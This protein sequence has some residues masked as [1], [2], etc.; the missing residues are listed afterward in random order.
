MGLI[1]WWLLPI[2]AIAIVAYWVIRY[3]LK[4]RKHVVN[5]TSVP[6]AHTSRLTGTPEYRSVLK[7]YK[8]VV[9]AAIGLMTL[10]M[11]AGI[12]LSA[13][14]AAV[15]STPPIQRSRD[16]MLCLDVSGSVLKAD[17][18]LLN[19][20]GTF[21][22]HFQGQR[23][24]L[25]V[26]NSSAV[27]I[28]PLNDNYPLTSQVLKSAAQA[29]KVQKD[30]PFTYFTTGTL[31]GFSNGTSLA[32]DGLA[33]CMQYLGPNTEH[34]SQSV[35]LSTD[36]E[37]FGKTIVNMTDDQTKAKKTGTHIYTIDPGVSD[38]TLADKHSELQTIA[39]Q[40]DGR[41]YQLKNLSIDTVVNDISQHEST[42]HSG[43]PQAA[44]TDLPQP[45]L[46][47]TAVAVIIVLG[48]MWRLEL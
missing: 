19:F 1:F 37:A 29:F 18:A 7:Q 15:L 9:G 44:N 31:A 5:S 24:G 20:Y 3:L 33:T 40:T 32:G 43:V 47:V 10:G 27:T 28:L 30:E 22:D 38:T 35:I 6:I 34:R 45:F 14:P 42:Y 48:L 13:R 8:I 26:F 25:T 46:Y 41:Y 16:I 17:S 36:N 39:S 11:I 21:V 12:I 23:F 4:R 2:W